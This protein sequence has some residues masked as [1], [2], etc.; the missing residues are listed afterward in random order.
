MQNNKMRIGKKTAFTLIEILV[1][2]AII[3]ILAAILFPV[4]ARAREN[5]RRSSCMSNLKQ[6][7]LGIMQYT[8]DNDEA[9]P[10]P[11][12]YN[13]ARAVL[14]MEHIFPYVK[15]NQVFICPSGPSPTTF[16][17]PSLT[18]TY[19]ATLGMNNTGFGPSNN[20]GGTLRMAALPKPAQ[21][22][23]VIDCTFQGFTGY[24]DY[25]TERHF[26]GSDMAFAD[27]HVKWEKKDFYEPNAT[28]SNWSK[29]NPLWFP[30]L[31]DNQ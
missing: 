21:F 2:I 18:K 1:V 5:A 7:G 19:E 25:I 31:N 14:W 29:V 11:Y 28:Y 3:A 20:G 10:T 23:M 4:F 15:S 13:G 24:N 6:L 12:Y 30:Q 8:Q 22:I 26:D 27:G 9:Y 16:D 17:I